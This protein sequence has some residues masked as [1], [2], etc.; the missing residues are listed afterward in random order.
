M[1]TLT[2]HLN[3]KGFKTPNFNSS[4]KI[5]IKTLQIYQ[6]V[7]F[8]HTNHEFKTKTFG[9]EAHYKPILCLNFYQFQCKKVV[10]NSFRKSTV[11]GIVYQ[12]KVKAMILDELLCWTTLALFQ[13]ITG[14]FGSVKYLNNCN[15]SPIRIVLL[16]FYWRAIFRVCYHL[17]NSQRLNFFT[18]VLMVFMFPKILSWNLLNFLMLN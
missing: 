10:W 11:S 2:F 1:L 16:Q 15:T 9:V 8:C 4:Y 18:N 12:T 7:G 17:I 3:N 5:F 13:N 6:C 14:L